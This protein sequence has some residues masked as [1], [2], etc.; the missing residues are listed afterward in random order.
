MANSNSVEGNMETVDTVI[1]KAI[2]QLQGKSKHPDETRIY[3]FVKD[4]LDDS[5]VSDGSFWE[6]MK[7]L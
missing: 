7:I 3:S 1:F 6:R 4:F 5:S 2:S